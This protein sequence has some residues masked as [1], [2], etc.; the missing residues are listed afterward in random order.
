MLAEKAARCDNPF[1][2]LTLH[3]LGENDLIG[4]LMNYSGRD[5]DARLTLQK[6]WRLTPLFGDSSRPIPPNDALVIRLE[7]G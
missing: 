7:K 6:D 3:P 5:Q 1:I 2:G 4:V